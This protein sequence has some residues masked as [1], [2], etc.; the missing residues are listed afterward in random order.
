MM[1]DFF[2]G[3]LGAFVAEQGI[4]SLEH[5]MRKS[6]FGDIISPEPSATNS[7]DGSDGGDMDRLRRLRARPIG[8]RSG[9][10]PWQR[11]TPSVPPVRPRRSKY[12]RASA[13]RVCHILYCRGQ[14]PRLQEHWYRREAV[15][16]Q[17][18]GLDRLDILVKRVI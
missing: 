12:L 8:G 10:R 5:L 14:L 16:R 2:D 17:A 6:G 11:G 4:Y 15:G 13:P 3:H 7:A 1:D 18:Q 9:A